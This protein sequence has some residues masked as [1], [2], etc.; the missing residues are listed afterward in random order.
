MYAQEDTAVILIIS[1]INE[2]TLASWESKFLIHQMLPTLKEY[3]R[4]ETTSV[5]YSYNSSNFFSVE[6]PIS[7]FNSSEFYI[8]YHITRTLSHNLYTHIIPQ[9]GYSRIRTIARFFYYFFTGMQSL[10]CIIPISHIRF[11]TF[12]WS[13]YIF[14]LLPPFAQFR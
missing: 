10:H 8:S 4:A 12:L 6:S 13:H 11:M 14:Y 7:W 3:W 9:V 1:L 5:H 2:N